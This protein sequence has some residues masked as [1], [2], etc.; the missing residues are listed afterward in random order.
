M[1]VSRSRR[2]APAAVLAAGLLWIVPAPPARACSICRCGDPTFN[3]LGTDVYSEAQFRIAFDFDR[4]QKSQLTFEDGH[5]GTDEEVEYRYTATV[6]YGFGD[7][8]LLVARVPVSHRDLTTTFS[9]DEAGASVRSKHGSEEVSTTGL[10]DPEFYALVRLWSS[11]FGEGLGKRSTVSAIVGVKTPWGR[12]DVQ[13]DGER[14]DEHAQPGTGSTDLFGGLSG[15]YLLDERSTIF[16]S[17][18]YRGTGRNDFGYKYGDITNATLAYERKITEPLDAVLEFD[19]RHAKRDQV[20]FTGEVDPNTGGT[21]LYITPRVL[22]GLSPHV[23]L[24]AAVQIP[25]VEN[26]YGVQDE[27]VNVNGGLTL[28]F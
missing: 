24:R 12:N 10:S 25:I 16:G 17:V 23:A 13:R 8:V 20:D 1:S 22:Y 14:V 3:S 11:R 27:K 4:F 28:L 19:F 7:R 2:L 5:A 26:L 9:D 15:Y 21:I 6:S 18:Q